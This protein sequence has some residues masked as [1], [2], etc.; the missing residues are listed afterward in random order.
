[1]EQMK[2]NN[3]FAKDFILLSVVVPVY[4]VPKKYLIHCLDSINNQNDKCNVEVILIDDGSNEETKKLLYDYVIDKPLFQLIHQINLGLS[5]ARNTGEKLSKGQWMISIDSDDYLDIDAFKRIKESISKNSDSSVI[6]FASNRDSNGKITRINDLS[7][8]ENKSL[9]K[10]EWL[11][12]YLDYNAFITSAYSKVYNLKFLKDNTLYHNQDLRQGAEG[13]E[14]N[15]RVF[16]KISKITAINDAWYYYVYNPESI[17]SCQSLKNTELTTKCFES[18][19]K[20]LIDN[21]MDYLKETFYTRFLYVIVTTFISCF[22]H[23][24]LNLKYKDRK[25]EAKKY[26]NVDLVKNSLKFGNISILDKKRKLILIFVKNKYF[27]LL[28]KLGK[29][30]NKQKTA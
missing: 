26:L 25:A 1:M 13:I 20:N 14:F 10:E 22:F 24:N 11:K 17:S 5:G 19:E 9:S 6:L 21:Q 2:S 16:S 4:N 23:P 12:E 7:L 3:Q 27:R 30:R 28:S 15:F 18:I 8:Y 29:M